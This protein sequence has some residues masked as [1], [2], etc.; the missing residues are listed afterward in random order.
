MMGNWERKSGAGGFFDADN[1]I[2][3]PLGDGTDSV[4]EYTYPGCAAE[5]IVVT[6]IDC[7]I[8]SMS[9]WG[10]MILGLF[11]MIMGILVIKEKFSLKVFS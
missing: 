4:F 11:F 9:Q 10:V 8:P 3:I 6:L 1:G 2:Y 7:G 5:E